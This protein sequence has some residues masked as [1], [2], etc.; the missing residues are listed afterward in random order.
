VRM[1][2]DPK[3]LQS[4]LDGIRQVLN[5]LQGEVE[6]LESSYEQVLRVLT[7]LQGA[8]CLD[9]LTGLLR[10]N[11][12][13]KKWEQL[14]AECRGLNESCGVLLIDIDHFKRVNDTY[15]HPTGDEV[16]RRLAGL[17]KDFESPTQFSGRL[18]GEEFAVAVR[19]SD[20]EILS[21]A[22]TIRRGAEKLHGPVI[23]DDSRND[24]KTDPHQQQTSVEW[25]CTVSVGMASVASEKQFDAERLIQA[26][27]R[28][29]YDAKEK[30]RNQ[31]RAA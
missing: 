10:R 6:V 9:D 19:G 8:V 21:I 12:F 20:A 5:H 23:G 1:K 26:A 24:S 29:L 4:S 31:V 13:F 30:G 27:D 16:I 22:E 15:G 7:Q 2:T 28:A 17:L 25:R 14:L 3:H 11:A 18:G